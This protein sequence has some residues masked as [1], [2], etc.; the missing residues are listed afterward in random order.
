MMMICMS[1]ILLSYP[2][3]SMY[4]PVPPVFAKNLVYCVLY[5]W[6]KR[7]PTAQANIWGIPVPANYLPFAYLALSVFMGNPFMDQLHGM[8]IG[9]VYYF[10]AEVVPQV[11]GKDLLVTPQF[12]LDKFG[13]GEYR[14]ERP[15]AVVV[16]GAG[17]GAAARRAGVHDAPGGAGP[18]AAAHV[19][20]GT[21]RPLG[22]D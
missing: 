8:A 11:Q 21:G 3:V 4:F 14:P 18:A 16:P 13:I 2:I 10:L 20:G 6:S 17:T 22:R 1:L 19:W 7:H 15:P 12:L 9:H 5:V